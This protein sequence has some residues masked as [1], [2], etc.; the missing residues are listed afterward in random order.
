LP[1]L[2]CALRVF[3]SVF[4]ACSQAK[5]PSVGAPEVCAVARRARLRPSRLTHCRPASYSARDGAL[6]CAGPREWDWRRREFCY[7]RPALFIEKTAAAAV[8]ALSMTPTVSYSST[9]SN[10]PITLVI[11]A[12]TIDSGGRGGREHAFDEWIDVEKTA[13]LKGIENALVLLLALAGIEGSNPA[14]TP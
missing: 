1:W 13:S 6:I 8:R 10:I 3:S 11:P 9:D 12:I 14:L 4:D 7:P 2:N 5:A